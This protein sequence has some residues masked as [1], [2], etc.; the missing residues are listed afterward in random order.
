MPESSSG[1]GSRTP[2]FNDVALIPLA[3]RDA[4]VILLH[5][6][7]VWQDISYMSVDIADCPLA[8]LDL[9]RVWQGAPL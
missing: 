2:V 4:S 9:S 5:V 3:R 7:D 6:T 1:T 8:G